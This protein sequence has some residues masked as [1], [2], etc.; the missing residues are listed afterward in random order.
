MSRRAAKLV[1]LRACSALGLFRVSAWMFRKRLPILCYHG[2]ELLEECAFRPQLFMTRKTLEGRLQYIAD[3]GF[4]VLP[5]GEALLRLRSGSLPPRALV[6]T[7]DDGFKSTLTV[8]GPLLDGMPATVYVT[9]YYMQKQVPIFGLAM[10]YVFWKAKAQ[11]QDFSG[12]PEMEGA[13]DP[14]QAMQE[15]IRRGHKMQREQDRQELLRHTASTLNVDLAPLYE[16]RLL[17]IMSVEELQELSRLGIEVQLHTHRHRFPASDRASAY[18]EIEENRIYLKQA[19]GVAPQHFCYPSGIFDE[20]QWPWLDALGVESATTCLPGLN[21]FDTPRYG[22]RR[23]LDHEGVEF[24]EF[25]AELAG[26]NEI[27]RWLRRLWAPAA[28]ESISPVAN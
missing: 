7:I 10:Q 18:R 26:F 28:R 23:F 12:L 5:L 25:K 17:S 14:E 11:R 9:T 2:F 21:R 15:L 1:L 19:V 27:L 16:Q 22:L 4:N 20:S 13:K 24:I 3:N 6:I 8:A